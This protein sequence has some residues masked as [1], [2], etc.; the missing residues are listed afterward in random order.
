MLNQVVLTRIGSH[1][2]FS[3]NFGII[4]NCLSYLDA[5][6]ECSRRD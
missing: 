2:D 3:K 1:F 4:K 5:G 6:N